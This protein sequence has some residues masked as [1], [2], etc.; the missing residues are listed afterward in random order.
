MFV[1]TIFK[2][3][4]F[5]SLMLSLVAF[6]I[7]VRSYYGIRNSTETG[8]ILAQKYLTSYV[9]SAGARAMAVL[10]MLYIFFK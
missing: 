2:L 9:I 1:D 5:S 3:L 10:I 4:L 7:D 8:I 6:V